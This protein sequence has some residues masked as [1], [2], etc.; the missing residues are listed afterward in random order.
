GIRDF[1]VTGVQTCALP[2][3]HLPHMPA[4]LALLCMICVGWRILIHQGRLS[5]PGVPV[6]MGMVALTVA[7]IALDFGRA[8]FSTEATVSVLKIGRASC[9]EGGERSGGAG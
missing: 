6:R 2:I 9:R 4:W 8:M 7:A 1:H 5:W 3:S